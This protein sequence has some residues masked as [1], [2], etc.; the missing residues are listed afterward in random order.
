M[1]TKLTVYFQIM[2]FTLQASHGNRI[3]R[4]MTPRVHLERETLDRMT[5][6]S[7]ESERKPSHCGMPRY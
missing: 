1:S 5:T 3:E 2:S 7:P 4:L 6:L